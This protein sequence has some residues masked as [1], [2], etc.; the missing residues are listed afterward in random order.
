MDRPTGVPQPTDG[1]DTSVHWRYLEGRTL[2]HALIHTTDSTAVC[3]T[4]PW[5]SIEWRGTGSQTEYENAAAYRCCKRCTRK[6]QA[7]RR[8]PNPRT[9]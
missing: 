7:N 6:L 5:M 1:R 2:V 8:T 9:E 4:G 3:G